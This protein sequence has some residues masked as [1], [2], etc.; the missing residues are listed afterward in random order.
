MRTICARPP[1]I[2]HSKLVGAIA[3][4]IR[5]SRAVRSY[6]NYLASGRPAFL[7]LARGSLNGLPRALPIFRRKL[8]KPREGARRRQ[9]MPAID[10]D[11]IAG[12][13]T[14]SIRHQKKHEIAQFI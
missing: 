14:A 2:A 6:W 10:A 3:K 13:I 1:S 11:G 8:R 9:M 12:D 5:F 7:F 4:P